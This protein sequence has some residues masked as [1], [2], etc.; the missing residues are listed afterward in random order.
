MRLVTKKK[1]VE[2]GEIDSNVYAEGDLRLDYELILRGSLNCYPQKKKCVWVCVERKKERE[3][4]KKSV[5]QGQ[6][7]QNRNTN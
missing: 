5:N 4:N 6:V 7:G 3:R 1:E 2:M